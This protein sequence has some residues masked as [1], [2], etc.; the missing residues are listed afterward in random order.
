MNANP[1]E[2]VPKAKPLN[3]SAPEFIPVEVQAEKTSREVAEKALQEGEGRRRKT[4][5]G[6]KSRKSKKRSRKTRRR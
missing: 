4:R 2:V 6:K 5:K 1:T 3:A